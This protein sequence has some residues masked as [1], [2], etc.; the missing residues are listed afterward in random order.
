MLR[1]VAF[2]I[3]AL[4]IVPAAVYASS[5]IDCSACHNTGA[6]NIESG[7]RVIQVKFDGEKFQNSVHG[8]LTCT[9]CHERFAGENFHI[10]PE[11]DVTPGVKEISEKIAPKGGGDPVAKAACSK[12]HTE[13]YNQMLESAHGKNIAEKGKADGPLCT[14]CHGSPHYIARSSEKDSPVNQWNVVNTCG[15]CHSNEELAKKYEIESDVMGSYMESFHGKKHIMGHKG[16]PTCVDCHGSHGI[17]HGDDPESPV[18]GSNKIQTCDKCHSGANETFVPAITHKEVGPIPHY[19]EI[20]LIL[21]VLGTIGFVLLH[22]LI[23]AFSDIRD[24]LFRKTEHEPERKDDGEEVER[25]NIHF[26]IQHVLLFTT[27]LVL[28]FTGWGLKY[29]QLDVSHWLI[30]LSGGAETAGLLHRVAGVILVSTFIYHLLYVFY[31]IVSGKARFRQETTVVPM[32]KDATDLVQNF[33]YYLGMSKEPAT[34]G[35]FSYKQKFDYWAVFW[36]M[37]IIGSSGLALAF[38]I[39]ASA[40]IPE[41]I[42]GWIWQLLSIMHSD[43]ALLAVVFILFWH[44]Y[45]EHLK[46]EVFPMNWVFIT[47]KLTKK[48]MRHHHALEYE[49]MSKDQENKE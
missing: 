41:F 16:A 5:G 39:A 20:G 1:R 21:L 31:R 35:R 49:L 25:F 15:A 2:L 26:R 33:M 34:Y 8:F 17:R 18:F 13:T 23:E 19:A 32:L 14:D 4:L 12:C 3:L 45:N 22:F 40:L 29:A 6:E 42:T 37:A 30:R 28:A 48:E 9:D 36:G 7:D 38:P 10:V 27:F 11:G 43:E 46:P 47:G 44:F 24:S